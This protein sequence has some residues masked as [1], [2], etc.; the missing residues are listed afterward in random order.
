[1]STNSSGRRKR[2]A[3]TP[4]E[5]SNTNTKT[6]KTTSTSAYNRNFE[7]KL[8][9]YGVYPKGYDDSKCVGGDYLFGN[10]APL[11]DGTLVNAK[12]D[13]FVGARPEQLKPEIRNELNNLSQSATTPKGEPIF[14]NNA[15]T[16]T[17]TYQAGQLKLYTTHPAAPQE[18]DGRPEYI[19]TSLRSFAMT[20]SLDTFRKGATAY[21]NAR[22]WAKEQR[23]EFIKSAN[24]R[25]E[26]LSSEREST[27]EPCSP[28]RS[29]LAAK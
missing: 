3:G 10:L 7:Q 23:D 6:T 4:L 14:D 27:P 2:R 13:Y 24:E 17:S 9:D 25:H 20:D 16:I 22:D 12:P 21:R 19:M 11:T 8:I 29:T 1:M 18:S 26:L 28:G 5:G 15:Y